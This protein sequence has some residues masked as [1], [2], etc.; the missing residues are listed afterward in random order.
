[1]A[2]ITQSIFNSVETFREESLVALTDAKLPDD[3]AVQ[4]HLH[5]NK[6][7]E[8]VMA[9]AIGLTATPAEPTVPT[10]P[11][12][13]IVPNG[14]LSID[15]G[16]ISLSNDTSQNVIWTDQNGVSTADGW[17]KELC[18][19]NGK[20][21]GVNTTSSFKKTANRSG[22]WQIIDNEIYA[23]LRT[24]ATTIITSSAVYIPA[25]SA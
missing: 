9:K 22:T 8:E 16:T 23:D 5:V 21:F 4:L 24:V 1:M 20:V 25:A 13:A 6:A 19:V 15:F 17:L 3:L 10:T 14:S 11:T 2:V 18:V 7:I 12:Q